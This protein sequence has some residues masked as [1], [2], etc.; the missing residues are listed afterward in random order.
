MS[1]T[2]LVPAAILGSFVL[3]SCSID[4][5]RFTSGDASLYEAS[6]PIHQW[7]LTAP[8]LNHLNQ[9]LAEHRAGWR[10]TPAN[11][12]PSLLLTLRAGDQMSTVNIHPTF[13]VVTLS[14]L[15][16]EQRF[17]EAQLSE[18]RQ[19]LTESAKTANLSLNPDASPAALARLPL[20]AG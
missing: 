7:N 9:W 20:G 6:R 16:Y 13:V 12:V 1:R 8:Q 4:I 17:T 18:L 3:V 19:G 11:F 14:S 5:P 15:S 10:P 2:L